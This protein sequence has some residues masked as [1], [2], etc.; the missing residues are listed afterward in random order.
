MPGGGFSCSGRS[1]SGWI[2]NDVFIH[3][4]RDQAD[5]ESSLVIREHYT[6]TGGATEHVFGLCQ[7]LGFRFAP[8]LRDLADRRLYVAEGHADH[9][10]LD[11]LIGGII[12][13][14]RIEEN[15]DE[16]LRM[17][18]SIRAGTV[19]PSVLLR[20]LAA[21]P[22]QNALARALREVGCL[23]RTLFILDWISDPAL[24]RQDL[25]LVRMRMRR[26]APS[27]EG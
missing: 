19:A 13:L 11:S 5:H 25:T 2:G 12:N 15:W 8:R 17:A 9:G 3:L 21:Y 23:E 6:D 26:A 16:I 20:R 10:A 24:R 18:A 7:L 22:R 1:E 27:L 14:C 4:H